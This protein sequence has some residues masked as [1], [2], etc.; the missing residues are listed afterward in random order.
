MLS[1]DE[2]QFY[3]RQLGIPSWGA[4]AQEKLKNSKVFV[5]G[6]GGLGSPVLYYLAAAGVG[7]L[8]LCDYDRVDVTNL[9]RQ[10]LHRYDRIGDPKVDSA[11]EALTCLNPFITIIPVQ[12]KLTNKNSEK[13]IGDSHIIIDCLDNF[14]ARHVINR[15][16]VKKRIPMIHAG[17]AEFRGQLTF[18][19]PPETPCLAC[20]LDQKSPKGKIQ[21]AGATPGVMGS[22]QAVEAIK[23][24]AGY[25]PI[26]EK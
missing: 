16:S 18:L 17:V 14:E 13:I 20:F 4:S 22:L 25:R 10:I 3:S 8:I 21:V 15:V 19:N 6:S 11:C 5:A 7:T 24:L 23:Y 1:K 26:P 2:L 12:A 9:N